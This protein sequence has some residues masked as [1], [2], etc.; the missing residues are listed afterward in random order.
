MEECLWGLWDE[1]CQP[2]LDDNLVHSKSFQDHVKH[3]Q[4]ILKQYQQHGIK[5]TAETCEL[6]RDHLRFLGKIVSKEGY[7]V[8]PAETAPVQA[9]KGRRP[10]TVGEVRQLL[11]FLSYYRSYIQDFS[12]LAKPLYD[13]LTAPPGDNNPL[14]YVLT[15]AKLNATGQRWVAELV[16]INFAIKYR[17]GKAN[18]D[19]DGLSRM[20]MD[21]EKY[22][23]L[24]TETVSQETLNRVP[25]HS[26]RNPHRC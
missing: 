18:A 21:F 6:F 11:R 2:Y 10:A 22:L 5:N 15:A 20:S 23:N 17:P 9:L 19:A 25:W 3:I 12:R 16:D 13:L 24:C 26:K 4:M 1:I 8:D 14:T 7:T